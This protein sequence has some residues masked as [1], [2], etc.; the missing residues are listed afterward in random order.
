MTKSFCVPKYE[1]NATIQDEVKEGSRGHLKYKMSGT[2]KNGTFKGDILVSCSPGGKSRPPE[3]IYHS[4]DYCTV[5]IHWRTHAACPAPPR[6]STRDK[7]QVD[8]FFNQT[9]W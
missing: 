5:S 7:V 6:G 1:I 3:L 4:D 8:N 9:F 2:G